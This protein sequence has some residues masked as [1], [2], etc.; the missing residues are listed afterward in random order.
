MGARCA[1]LGNHFNPCFLEERLIMRSCTKLF[2]HLALGLGLSAMV[3]TSANAALVAYDSFDYA[4]GDLNG[5]NG[6]TG[7]TAAW[8]ANAIVD[9]V[10]G[11][12]SYQAG[13]IGVSGGTKTAQVTGAIAGPLDNAASRA[14]TG[15]SDTVYVSFL[16]RPLVNGGAAEDDFLQFMLNDDT[17]Q[18]NSGSIGMRN[19]TGTTGNDGYFGRIRD[20]SAETNAEATPNVLSVVG[21]T[22]VL[23]AKFSKVASANYN[24]LDLFVNPTSSIEGAPVATVS[25]DSGMGL[26]DVFSL[27]LAFLDTG[28][29][30]QFDELRIGT[31]FADVIT[32]IPEPA[33]MSL[34]VMGLLALA[35]RRRKA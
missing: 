29:A 18:E 28:D 3:A 19:I 10:N 14:F 34:G 8:S 31:T 35:A 17:D 13:N 26:A 15:Q 1:V 27:R 4:V 5:N 7:F 21:R 23:I 30:Y 16:F 24:R 32:T 12:L 2:K 9:V 20:G 6:G 25:R 33:T 22:D 11:S